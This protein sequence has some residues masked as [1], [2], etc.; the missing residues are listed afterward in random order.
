MSGLIQ[1]W[2]AA[3]AGWGEWLLSSAIQ[4]AA[5]LG[6]VLMAW[7]M[8]RKRISAHFAY[9][10]FLLP[11]IPLA[12]PSHGSISVKIGNDSN[13]SQYVPNAW[14]EGTQPAFHSNAIADGKSSSFVSPALSQS[15]ATSTANPPESSTPAHASASITP[16]VSAWV[17]LIW[18]VVGMGLLITF[19]LTQIR[20]SKQ[21][22]RS[23]AVAPDDEL[24]IQTILRKLDVTASFIIRESPMASSPALWG[25][26][27]P[28]LLFPPGLL[29][30]LDDQ[31]LAWILAHEVAH[32]KRFDLLVGTTQRLI[33][34]VWFFH[35]L[36]WWQGKRI[37][38]LRECACDEA[39]QAQTQTRGKEC[40]EALLQ[41][42]AQS[43]SYP[44]PLF[45]LQTLHHH[46]QNMKQRILRLMNG[47]RRSRTTMKPLAI[48]VLI[49]AA[50]LSATSFS[51]Q[52][53][54]APQNAIAK[55][56]TWL[57]EQQSAD[58]SWS[59]GPD[60]KSPAGEFT[61]VGITGLVLMSLDQAEAGVDDEAR[62]K[63]IAQGLE[64]LREPITVP[65]KFYGRKRPFQALA[66]HAVATH[67][68]LTVNPQ[69][70][71]DEWM[72]T[73][74]KAVKV[75]EQSRNPYSGWGFEFEPTG[76]NNTI[77][78]SLA[79]QAAAAA[80]EV[81]IEI[82]RG[83][84]EGGE[85]F[86]E[87]MLDSNNGRMGYS[88]SHAGDVRIIEK[89]KTHPVQHT[90]LCT[91]IAMV[92]QSHWGLNVVDEP[93]LMQGLGLIASKRPTWNSDNSNVDYFF[94][95]YGAQAM[96]LVGG[97]FEQKWRE[98]LQE[99]L[100]PRQLGGEGLDGAFP[101]V[102]A[103]SMPGA[104]IHATVMATLALQAVN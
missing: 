1:M 21:I 93:H 58:G 87:S 78:T 89:K 86:F 35:P 67:A 96:N 56:Q 69:E 48:P 74:K 40:A 9:A 88:H 11:L 100:L 83:F 28:C 16:T 33:Q 59:A 85:M 102:D 39:A 81:G 38:H 98:D 62:R 46:K 53:D 24:R 18:A 77:N 54:T 45:A 92:A 101:A 51:L 70:E 60:M 26:R 12:A 37:D 91:A 73:A 79:L 8:L 32:H 29:P 3:A 104:T 47:D 95:Y 31:Q 15:S 99:V 72:A 5:V 30:K 25:I 17:F 68:W 34:I 27:R 94:W 42:A 66:S 90:E 61:T 103:W 10:L 41:V 6:I 63:A 22:K 4:S 13:W 44:T 76:D 43:N 19:A 64:Y 14:I 97:A 49:F 36:V 75:L 50:A 2:N 52:S 57:I 23:K 71:N 7:P 80:R 84:Y 82:P 55:A 20:V 65:K